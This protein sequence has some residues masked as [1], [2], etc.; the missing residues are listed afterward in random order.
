MRFRPLAVLRCPLDHLPLESEGGVLRCAN[1][2][3][4]DIATQ[5][6]VNL[7]G[8]QHKRSRDPGDTKEMVAARHRFLEAGYYQPLSDHLVHWLQSELQ[9]D[10]LVVDAG[11]GEGY[12]LRELRQHFLDAGQPEPRIVGFDISKWAVQRAARRFPATWM[13]ASNRNI[14]LADNSVDVVLDVFGFPNV[15]EF[16]RV[17]KSSGFLV[18]VQAAPKHLLELRRI[19]YA[20]IESK[21]VV[22]SEPPGFARHSGARVTYDIDH[23]GSEGIGDLLL[24][25]PHLFRASAEGKRRAAG[26]Q[27][28]AVTVDVSVDV[29]QRL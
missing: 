18:R 10:S 6:Y 27:V 3:S 5:G 14:P 29:F 9:A 12:Y 2:H 19:I 28:L 7:L 20:K 21:D 8:A 22:N 4:F 17:L 16:S 25:T 23:L 11:C 26:L 15:E 1:Q 13:V 24:M